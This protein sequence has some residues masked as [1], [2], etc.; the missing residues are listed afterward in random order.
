M[1]EPILQTIRQERI[2]ERKLGKAIGKRQ[3]VV[4]KQIMEDKPVYTLDHVIKERYPT[5]VDA[6]RDLDDALSMIALF[7]TLPSNDKVKASSIK[8]CQRLLAEFQHYVVLSGS[9]KKVFLSIKG[10]YY[11]AEIK[12]QAIT[13]ITPYEFAQDLPH[14][15]DF[16]VMSTFLEVHETLLSF[17]NYK[18]YAELNLTYPPRLDSKLLEEGAGLSAYVVE[19]KDAPAVVAQPAAPKKDSKQFQARVKS[20]EAKLASIQND[21]EEEP[22]HASED[23]TDEAADESV[24]EPVVAPTTVEEQVVTMDTSNKSKRLFSEAVFFISREVPRYSVEF[25]IK[26]GGGKCGWDETAGAGSPYT[27][28]DKRITHHITDRPSLAD[29][30]LIEGREYLQPQWIYD[31][32]NADK[33][34]KTNNYHPGEKL[35]PHLSPFVVMGEDD[36]NPNEEVQDETM[37]EVEESLEETHAAEIEAETAGVPFSEF[38]PIAKKAKAAAVV[39]EDKEAKELSKIMMSRRDK[40]LYDKIQ[41]GKARKAQAVEKLRN[42]KKR[43]AKD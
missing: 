6:L 9:L 38:K 1:H 41:F 19:S 30:T 29:A 27:V 24:P 32:I 12:G 7:A 33:L 13:W 15:V 11:Q 3:Y 40:K 37:E 36:Y 2:H 20:L 35:P 5:F 23:E 42:K 22:N 21:D 34:V 39:D 4:A 25:I 14:D 17:V 26:A 28:D 8:E 31:C 16:R 10:I 43:S 18:L